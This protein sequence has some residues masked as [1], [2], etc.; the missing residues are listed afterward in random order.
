[1]LV[2]NESVVIRFVSVKVVLVICCD[3]RVVVVIVIYNVILF[4]VSM[5]FGMLRVSLVII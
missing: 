1:M 5:L 2:S 3:F 4:I